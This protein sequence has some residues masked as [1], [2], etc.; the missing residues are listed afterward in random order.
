[1]L[2]GCF[3][4]PGLRQAFKM[5]V[6]PTPEKCPALGCSVACQLLLA[7]DDAPHLALP[8]HEHAPAA[9]HMATKARCTH[10]AFLCSFVF[11]QVQARNQSKLELGK[12]GRAVPLTFHPAFNIIGCQPSVVIP[13]VCQSMQAYVYAHTHPLG[14][15][16][17]S[18][19]C[20]CACATSVW[21]HSHQ[22][23]CV[24]TFTTRA[25]SAPMELVSVGAC[26]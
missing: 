22:P 18:L 11:T 20:S 16:A 13:Q 15:A 2:P 8:A 10:N 23:G 9:N 21:E 3:G 25:F 1:M 17:C 19:S 6:S 4:L 24:S 26:V 14:T 12:W 7:A 5:G